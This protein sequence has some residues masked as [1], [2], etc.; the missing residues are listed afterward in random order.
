[1]FSLPGG[2]LLTNASDWYAYQSSN[3]NPGNPTV[4]PNTQIQDDIAAATWSTPVD[5]GANGT[6]GSWGTVT[7]ITTVAH[8]IWLDSGDG[9]DANYVLFRSQDAVLAAVPLPP[10]VLLLGSGL[11]G[12]VGFRRLRK[13]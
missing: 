3:A 1:Q 12:L 10:A 11:L 5:F 9:T 4:L 8:Y 13:G 6:S 2:S 7:G